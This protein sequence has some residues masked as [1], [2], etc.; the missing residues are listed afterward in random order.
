M[1]RFPL[2]LALVAVTAMPSAV[3]GSAQDFQ[4]SQLK[5]KDNGPDNQNFRIFANQLGAA[6]S[7][8]NFAPPETLGQSGFNF[9]FEYAV[10]QVD[11]AKTIWP[12]EAATP[13]GLL[14]MPT[15][16]MRKGLPFSFE[17]G[18][19]VSYL[20]SSQMVAA[21]IEA[22]WALNEGF[23]YF[24]DLGVRGY[25]T[26]LVGTRDFSLTTAGVD[27]GIGHPFA[28]LGTATLTPYVG[29]NLQYVTASSQI[30]A[31]SASTKSAIPTTGEAS[32]FSTVPFHDNHNNRFYLGLRWISYIVEVAGEASVTKTSSA[33]GA[34]Q[35]VMLGG[36]VGL[37]F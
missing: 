28:I 32:A 30:V 18:T 33:A 23:F 15:L 35:I 6:I 10:V 2:L 12:T 11:T 9:A 3:F 26:H 7:S 21:T 16:H 19:K 36:K 8:F 27:V 22:K 29:W 14:L 34:K 20:Q 5:T 31:F 13:P 1:R 4:I 17:V 24:P 37:D 25:G